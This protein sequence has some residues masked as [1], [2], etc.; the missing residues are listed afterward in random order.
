MVCVFE[1]CDMGVDVAAMVSV[2]ELWDLGV[3]FAAVA[4]VI[5]F[6]HVAGAVVPG[7]AG[8]APGEDLSL[9]HI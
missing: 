3:E 4:D 7:D 6:F 2:I 1:L 9:I 8:G 5:L